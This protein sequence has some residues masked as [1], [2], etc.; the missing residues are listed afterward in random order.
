MSPTTNESFHLVPFIITTGLV[1]LME[2]TFLW[3]RFLPSKLPTERTEDWKFFPLLLLRKFILWF[4]NP[5]L[6]Y[7][8]CSS[9][10]S[11]T[12]QTKKNR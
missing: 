10:F 4:Y 7:I 2:P 6:I 1:Q 9:V 5:Y 12:F 11:I 3:L 8:Y